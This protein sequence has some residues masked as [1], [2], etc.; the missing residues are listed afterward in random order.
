MFEIN[1]KN[2]K[3]FTLIELLVVIA[4]IGLLA[5]I[6]LISLNAARDNA[7]VVKAQSEVR[8]LYE[9]IIRYHIDNIAWPTPCNNMDTVA[10]WNG[11]WKSGYI[12][13]YVGADPWGTSYFFD[14]CP[15][16]ECGLGQT[17]LCS[18]GPNGSFQSWNRADRTPQGDDI[19]IYFD[20]EC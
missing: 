6:V 16:S 5:T 1:W 14:G 18:A 19:C 17:A 7:K 13:S 4:I 9:A 20:P 8:I 2:R 15:D 10:E 11:A 3:G 12:N